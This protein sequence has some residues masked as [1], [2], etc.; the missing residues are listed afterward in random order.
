[1]PSRSGPGAF[2]LPATAEASF[3]P[4]RAMGQSQRERKCVSASGA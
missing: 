3:G 4:A 1:M 2:P